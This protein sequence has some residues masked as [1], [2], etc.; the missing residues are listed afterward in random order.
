MPEA[1]ETLEPK[2]DQVTINREAAFPYLHMEFFWRD[3]DLKFKVHLKSGQLLKY[4]NHGSVHTYHC[5][6]AIPS[7][8]L[9]RLAS[10]TFITPEN[11]NMTMNVLNPGHIKA[12]RTAQLISS[13]LKFKTLKE[14]VALLKSQESNNKIPEPT[15]EI[16]AKADKKKKR[17]SSRVAYFCIGYSQIWGKPI[18]QR[19]EAL[20]KKHGLSFLRTRM[21][22]HKFLNLGKKLNSDCTRRVMKDIDDKIQQDRPFNCDCRLLSEDKTCCFGSNCQRSMVVYAIFCLITQKTYI[23][24]TQRYLKK[25]TMEH[26]HDVWKVI[27]TGQ[28]KKRHKLVRQWRLFQ[29]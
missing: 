4:L 7:G 10:L 26:I 28:K 18:H 13:N 24:K 21:S 22:Y 29:S 2:L 12:L 6:K 11:E 8:V 3:E 1:T 9:R 15:P 23:G 20:R 27:E 14:Q 16:K 17:D 19:L 25:R 5:L